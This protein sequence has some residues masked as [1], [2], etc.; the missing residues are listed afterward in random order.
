MAADD[1]FDGFRR[2]ERLPWEVVLIAFNQKDFACKS[3][4]PFH[5]WK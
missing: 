1:E 2:G 4:I 3:G 5:L